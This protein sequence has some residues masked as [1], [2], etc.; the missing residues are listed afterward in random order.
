M[1]NHLPNPPIEATTIAI[2]AYDGVQMS[3]VLGLEDLFTIANRLCAVAQLHVTILSTGDVVANLGGTYG[4]IIM[5]P[6]INAARGAGDAAIHSFLRHQHQLGSTICSA[7]AGVFWLAESGLLSGRAVTTHWALVPEFAEKYPNVRLLPDE[8]L[9]DER[10]IVTAGGM[11]AWLDLGLSLV[12][13]HLGAQVMTDTARVH[14]QM[15]RGRRQANY[16][17]FRPRTTH[18]DGAISELQHWMAANVDGDLSI[19][20]L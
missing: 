16:R 17:A 18:G 15:P 10:D 7:C 9:I 1:T 20:T 5:P 8:I 11:M 6:N 4:A 13:R 19:A 12:E 14:Q 3:A 2:I